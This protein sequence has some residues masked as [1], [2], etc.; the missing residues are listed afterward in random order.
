[1]ASLFGTIGLLCF[2]ASWLLGLGLGVAS[3]LLGLEFLPEDW[4]FGLELLVRGV[5]E[6]RSGESLDLARVWCWTRAV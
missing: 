2:L 3:W 4:L 5:L 6:V 1:M